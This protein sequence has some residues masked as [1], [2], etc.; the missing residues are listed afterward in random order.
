MVVRTVVLVLVAGALAGAQAPV[1]REISGVYP[2][3]A[4]FNAGNE[5]GTGAVVPWADRLWVLTY[6]PHQPLGSDD[7]LYE[8]DA[9]LNQVV[10]P[11]SIG[12]T[13]AN[14][15]IHRESA[16]LFIG[17]YAI[18]QASTVRVIPYARM[19]GRPTGNARHLTRPADRIYCATMEEGLYEVD[20]RT[21]AVHQIFE[22]A[23]MPQQRKEAADH[24]GHLLPGY[25]GKGLY[26]GQG[27]LVYANNGEYGGESMPPD[28]PSGCLAEWNGTAWTVVRRNQF[29]EVTGPGGLEGNMHPDRDPI[30]SI[31]WDHRSL[32]LMLLDG[33]DWHAYRLPKAS[34]AYDGAHGWNTEWPRIRDIGEPDLLMTM[35]GMFWRLPR[36]FS[37]ARSAGIAPRSTYLRVVGDFARWKDRV[38]FGSDDT[39]RSEFTNTRVAKGKI[40]APG[41]SQSNLWFVEPSRLDRLGVPI[42]RG[43]VWVRDDLRAGEPSEPFLFS[44][45]ERRMV[46]LAHESGTEVRFTFEVDRAGDGHWSRL[47]SVAVP[48]RGYVPVFFDAAERGAWV[49]VVPDRDCRRATAFFQYSNVDRRPAAPSSIFDSLPRWGEST[50]EVSLLWARDENKRTLLHASA[51]GLQELDVNLHLRE[52]RDRKTREWMAANL[53]A[54]RDALRA[55]AA[56][57]IYTDETGQRW[58]LPKGTPLAGAPSRPVRVDREVST[59][60][61]L[62]NAGGIFYEL[63]SNNA[64]GIAMVRPVA[65][66]NLDIDDYCSWRGLTVMSVAVAGAARNDRLVRSSGGRAA[67][68]LGISDDLWQLGRARGEGGPWKDTAVRAGEPSDPYLMTGFDQKI[69]RLSHDRAVPLAM[70]VEVDLTGTGL[71]V[72]YATYDLPAGRAFEHRF[73]DGFNAYWLRTVSLEDARVTAQLSYR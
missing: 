70:R 47:R 29:T 30:W 25:H 35:H 71:W 12:G 15:M 38:V 8:I 65:T 16:Q 73:P 20:V 7:K 62:L 51:D 17:P 3:L 31:G 72:P 50:G 2:H 60:R 37:L 33:G 69:L 43:G 10:R 28:A 19:P 18:D 11:E 22:D 26:S 55:D 6:S 67:L 23:N 52:L 45:F 46:H 54:P 27:R 56:S 5:C 21:L 36:T 42:G 57:I 34:H 49:R 24:A 1:R 66:H 44:G 61:D 4:M 14:R 58:R 39:A 41:Q 32:I 53:A 68:W 40:A 9:R 64:G 13:P 59:E 63:P 48:A